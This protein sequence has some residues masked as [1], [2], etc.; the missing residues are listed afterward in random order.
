V[1]RW[2]ITGPIAQVAGWMRDLRT[3][4]NR[5]RQ[6]RGSPKNGRVAGSLISEA[7]RMAKSLA[8]ARARVEKASSLLA[9]T[10]RPGRPTA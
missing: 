6:A 4:K 7:S 1:V 8:I 2:S 9:R 10:N 5:G 3:G